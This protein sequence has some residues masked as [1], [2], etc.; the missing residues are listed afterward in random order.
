VVT[1]G[2]VNE[3]KEQF[4]MPR[5]DTVSKGAEPVLLIILASP[6]ARLQGN[7]DSNTMEVFG[8]V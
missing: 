3:T 7:D 2:S 6:V 5:I 4:K 1:E 8:E